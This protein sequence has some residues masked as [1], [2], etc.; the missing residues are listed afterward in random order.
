M[1]DF[2][3]LSRDLA[4]E[5]TALAQFRRARTIRDHS[6]EERP[7]M[8]R[9]FYETPPCCDTCG[10]C[11]CVGECTILMRR[12]PR[13]VPELSGDGVSDDTPALQ[14]FINAAPLTDAE[15]HEDAAILRVPP[16]T[17]QPTCPPGSVTPKGEHYLAFE[18]EDRFVA[19]ILRE[20]RMRAMEYA[21]GGH[22][23]AAD[24]LSRL[25]IALQSA[26]DA[27]AA[28][29]Q[30]GYERGKAEGREELA[31][32]AETAAQ[33]V[34]LGDYY[35]GGDLHGAS[36]YNVLKFVARFIRERGRKEGT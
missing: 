13:L 21:H 1:T 24:I 19:R 17:P 16:R 26:E 20:A 15:I 29:E 3:Q 34:P 11:G 31:V 23:V 33:S 8:P 36:R 27:I 4:H 6:P 12:E 25:V 2:D 14:A 32:Q 28:T 5:I 35:D 9:E 22:K 18:S 30:R 7:A 10:L